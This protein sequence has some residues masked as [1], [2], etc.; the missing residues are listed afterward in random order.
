MFVY[1]E[2]SVV[3]KEFEVVKDI[4]MKF[5]MYEKMYREFLEGGFGVL[6]IDC[7]VMKF[8]IL[9]MEYVIKFLLGLYI[10]EIILIEE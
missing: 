2:G 6:L 10:Y 9:E 5:K 7:F 1:G 4:L 8:F 3:W